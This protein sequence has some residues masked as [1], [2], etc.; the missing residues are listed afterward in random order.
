MNTDKQTRYAQLAQHFR[1][2]IEEGALKPGD[3]LSSFA[4]M[5]TLYGASPLTVDRAFSVLEKEGLIVRVQGS[6]TFVADLAAHNP[7][8]ESAGL[9]GLLL[10][11]CT[12]PFFLSIIE[13]VEEVAR[14]AG[15]H[16]IVANWQ[17]DPV[18][19]VQQIASLAKQTVG[20]CSFPGADSHEAYAALIRQ[21]VPFV[22]VDRCLDGFAVPTASSDNERGGYLATHHLLE[23]GR[24]R[25]YLLSDADVSPVCDRIRGYRRALKEAGVT[26]DP[27]LLRRNTTVAD[28]AG[29]TLT[30]ALL[31][32]E[33]PR[34][35]FGIFTI[36][37]SIARGCYLAL[38]EASKRIPQDVAVVGFDDTKAPFLE[39]PL[40]TVRQD[41]RGMGTTAARLLIKTIRTGRPARS[42]ALPVEL[43]V[44]DSSDT[45][46]RFCPVQHI[47]ENIPAKESLNATRLRGGEALPSVLSAT[48]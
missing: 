18:I 43:I 1:K 44:R 20:I 38:K 36:N 23:L 11:S 37:D 39:P 4:E 17:G 27:S 10:P 24:R 8:V 9:L 46:A 25:I 32:E 21:Q 30:R 15:Y 3:R 31:E 41:L 6:G 12:D 47:L 5:R 29:Y 13:G 34:E 40:S 26:Y 42:M 19:E 35:P 2:Q 45:Q 33:T 14:H 7:S 28:A 48:Q 16:L 22:F